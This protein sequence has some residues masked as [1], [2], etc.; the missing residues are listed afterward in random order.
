MDDKEKQERLA[1]LAKLISYHKAGLEQYKF[2]MSQSAQYLEEQTIKSLRD[3]E[4]IT[5][6]QLI[7]EKSSSTVEPES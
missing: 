3:L 1:K 4:L 5:E 2:T 6:V 7:T